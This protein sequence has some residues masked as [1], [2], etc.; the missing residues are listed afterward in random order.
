MV[1]ILKLQNPEEFQDMV[2]RKDIRISEFIVGNILKNLNT[3]KK[4]IKI[5]SINFIEDD[6]VFE[7]YVEK[8]NFAETLEEN[9]EHYVKHERYEDCQIIK[10]AIDKL[11]NKK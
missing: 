6:A 5:L 7:L 1:K 10:N 3:R 2:D 4:E 8:E 11:K 9:L